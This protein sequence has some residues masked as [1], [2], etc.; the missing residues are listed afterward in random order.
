MR[1]WQRKRERPV[2]VVDTI[3]DRDWMLLTN[4]EQRFLYVIERR[5]LGRST[6]EQ[7]ARDLKDHRRGSTL[8]HELRR[9]EEL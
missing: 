7:Y 8:S 9:V 2:T 5:Q 6:D 3:S 1:F 4:D